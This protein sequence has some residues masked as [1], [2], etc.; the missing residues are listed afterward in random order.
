MSTRGAVAIKNGSDITKD[1]I[2]VYN[3]FDSYPNGLGRDLW[4]H[5]QDKDIKRFADELLS[6]GDWREYLNGGICEYC[7]Q[8]KGQPCN[9]GAVYGFGFKNLNGPEYQSH[10]N[11]IAHYKKEDCRDPVQR[12]KEEWKIFENVKKTGYPD[13]KCKYHEHSDQKAGQSSEFDALF[14]EWVYVI[15]TSKYTITVLTGV[16]DKGRHTEYNIKGDPFTSPNY[17]WVKV[18]TW[19]INELPDYE[20][21]DKK[22]DRLGNKYYKLNKEDNE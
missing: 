4:E 8:K 17:M 2:G 3:H 9:I 16:R 21:T 12:A 1:W 15:D 11:L 22:G 18:D 20:K 7:G 13:P 10:E 6:Y 5:L 14:I 19:K